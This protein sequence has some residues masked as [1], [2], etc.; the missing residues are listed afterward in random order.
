MKRLLSIM[1]V[2]VVIILILMS[3]GKDVITME[4]YEWKMRT[5]MSSDM[6]KAQSEDELVIAVGESDDLYPDAKIIDLKLTAKDGELIVTDI[7]NGETYDGTYK[8][9]KQTP[10]SID[11]E[12]VINGLRG[13]AT[14]ASTEYYDG[15]EIPT[16]PINLGEYALYFI[17]NE[18]TEK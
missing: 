15:S 13:Y 1:P 17:P 9:M 11:Y 7:T 16:L 5:V 10:K 2:M 8:I 12:V 14:V 6:D 4:D 3:C 18:T